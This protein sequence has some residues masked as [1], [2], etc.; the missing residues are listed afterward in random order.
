MLATKKHNNQKDTI[1]RAWYRACN[2]TAGISA[3]KWGTARFL[4][5]VP[6]TDLLRMELNQA[7]KRLETM[8]INAP[9]VRYSPEFHSAVTAER[10]ARMERVSGYNEPKQALSD[11]ATNY[12][13]YAPNVIGMRR[14]RKQARREQFQNSAA[15]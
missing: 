9:R 11:L 5:L 2:F 8:D 10:L 3:M 1:R 7:R 12:I 6:T 15:A 4:S 14:N 13:P